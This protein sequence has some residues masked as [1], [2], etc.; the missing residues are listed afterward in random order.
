VSVSHAVQYECD[1]TIIEVHQGGKFSCQKIKT[2]I[3]VKAAARNKAEA[4]AARKAAVK[5]AAAVRKA[6][7]N[8]P[9]YTLSPK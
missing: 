2:K 1:P 7:I 9:A 6:E 5:R 4:V 3:K 8:N